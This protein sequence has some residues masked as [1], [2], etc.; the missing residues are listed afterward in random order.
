MHAVALLAWIVDFVMCI[1][2]TFN[3]LFCFDLGQFQ[4]MITTVI[5]M[6]DHIQKII[7]RVI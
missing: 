4:E 7:N 1:F 3:L 5:T 2:I 6:L